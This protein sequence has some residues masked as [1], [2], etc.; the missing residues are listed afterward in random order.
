MDIVILVLHGAAVAVFG[1]LLLYAAISDLRTFE[2]PNWVSGIVVASFLVVAS[3]SAAPWSEL[4]GNAITGIAVLCVGFGLFAAGLLGAGDVKLLAATAFWVGWPLLVSYLAVV[5]LFGGVISLIL[6]GF[7]RIPLWAGFAAIGW[8]A[9]LY[10]RKRDVPYAVA[11]G[12]TTLWFLPRI[13][14]VAEILPN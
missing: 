6:I 1:A 4:Q 5:I 3:T 14:L 2:V 11:I 8:I 12:F 13:P 7:R 9:R 10:E